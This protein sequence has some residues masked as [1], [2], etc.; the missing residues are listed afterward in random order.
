MQK[1]AFNYKGFLFVIVG[2]IFVILLILFT[3]KTLDYKLKK[4]SVETTFTY[5]NKTAFNQQLKAKIGSPFW[6]LDLKELKAQ[7]AQDPW[8]EKIELKRSLSGILLVKAQEKIPFARWNNDFL[9]DTNLNV[10]PNHPKVP[11]DLFSL[12]ADK[13]QLVYAGTLAQKFLLMFKSYGINLNEASLSK[14]GLWTLLI[15]DKILIELGKKDLNLK[16]NKLFFLWRAYLSEETAK[17]ASL[18]LRYPNGLAI[19]RIER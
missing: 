2:A 11:I 1:S 19:K 4:I 18:D 10:L 9:L 16:L 15:E 3:V 13:E 12:K 5:T 7:L 14:S 17:I 8:L 6:L